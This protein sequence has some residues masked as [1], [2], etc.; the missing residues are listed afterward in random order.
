MPPTEKLAGGIDAFID[1]VGR[2]V[3]WIALVLALVMGANVFLRYGFSLGWIWAQELEW[4][5][6]VPITL[7]GMSYAML[8]GDHVR[9]D[10]LYARFSPRAKLTVDLMS[11][12]IAMIFSGLVIW[13]SLAYVNQSWSIGEGSA[14]PGGLDYRY[15]IKAMIPAGFVLLL[16]Q[17]LSQA[18]R[19]ALAVKAA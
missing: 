15:I 11:A 9:V 3:S 16:L 10:V 2:A 13:L 14:N 1:L 4:H 6:L 7:V 5:L 17:S 12:V 18:I 8:H 19:A